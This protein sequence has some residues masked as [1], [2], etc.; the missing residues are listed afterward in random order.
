MFM[1]IEE[2]RGRINHE[3]KFNQ[4]HKPK[5]PKNN[6][7]RVFVP[8]NDSVARGILENELCR[9]VSSNALE[10]DR[11]HLEGVG[12]DVKLLGHKGDDGRILERRDKVE[13]QPNAKVVQPDVVAA[14]VLK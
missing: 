8:N 7:K 13:R 2:K 10:G 11:L 1:E 6:K 3:Q 4:K 12:H 5:N 9:V 14:H